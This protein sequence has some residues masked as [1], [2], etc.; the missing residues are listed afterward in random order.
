M[1]IHGGS[2]SWPAARWVTHS[3]YLPHACF[4]S[5]LEGL[6]RHR[7][8][9]IG[10][11]ANL[12]KQWC[13][14]LRPKC[15]ISRSFPQKPGGIESHASLAVLPHICMTKS[16]SSHHRSMES[17]GKPARN[18]C[19]ICSPVHHLL[20]CMQPNKTRPSKPTP[21]PADRT[22]PDVLLHNVFPGAQSTSF[23]YRI[24]FLIVSGSAARQ[25]LS[26]APSAPVGTPVAPAP[27][28]D[29]KRWREKALASYDT[30]FALANF[31]WTATAAIRW[32]SCYSPQ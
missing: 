15:I 27:P 19:V 26:R 17:S 18:N 20:R 31:C 29:R 10:K 12:Q 21:P 13:L 8:L 3:H 4:V 23:P 22:V 28:S 11:L 24:P 6:G 7:L 25:R 14:Q 32:S 5:P 1:M 16:S 2:N 9:S 30:L